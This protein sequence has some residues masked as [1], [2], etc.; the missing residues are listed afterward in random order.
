MMNPMQQ[1]QGNMQRGNPMIEQFLG[2]LMGSMMPQMPALPQQTM[3][4]GMGQMAKMQGSWNFDKAK[5][6]GGQ[7][8]LKSFLQQYSKY[9]QKLNTPFDINSLLRF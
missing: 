8:D 9:G 5:R 3:Q 7:T 4:G 2:K 6:M 1:Q